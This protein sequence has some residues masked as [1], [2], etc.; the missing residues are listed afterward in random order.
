MY[1]DA[2]LRAC[3]AILY[4]VVTSEA[5]KLRW[6][7]EVRSRLAAAEKRG[8]KIGGYRV[9]FL[10]ASRKAV[11]RTLVAQA[12][13]FNRQFPHDRCSQVDFLDILNGVAKDLRRGAA[14]VKGSG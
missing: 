4:Q 3:A 9:E 7:E 10:T 13:A 12:D 1:S 6:G 14:R 5:V 11:L 2:Q 8:E